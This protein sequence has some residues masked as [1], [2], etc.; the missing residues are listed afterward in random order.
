MRRRY[1]GVAARTKEL[2][3]RALYIHCYCH[4]NLSLQDSCTA[5]HL[6]NTLGTVNALYDFLE[7]SATR[8][9]KFEAVQKA[10]KYCKTTYNT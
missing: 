3:P 9:N 2:E 10:I 1:S 6:I 8:H 7:A 4:L 5:D